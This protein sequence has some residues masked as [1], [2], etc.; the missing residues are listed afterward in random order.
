MAIAASR[1]G[2]VTVFFNDGHYPMRLRIGELI[3]LQE[4]L[5]C[6]PA[7]LLDRLRSGAWGV[8]D[9]IETC[10]LG[11][12]GGGMGQKDAF[13]LVHRTVRDGYILEYLP[14][15]FTVVMAALT[16]VEDDPIEDDDDA[17][18]PMAPADSSVGA[19][20]MNSA[21]PQVEA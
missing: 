14:V 17:G 3:G 12:I 2:L 15:A 10:R 5:N 8:R 6:G 20:S 16:G 9:L 11:L 21:A 19:A 13:D 18:E 4:T 7:Q 1:S